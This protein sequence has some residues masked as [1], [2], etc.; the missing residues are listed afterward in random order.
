MDIKQALEYLDPDDDSHWTAEGLPRIEAVSSL[1]E[2]TVKRQEIT[3]A[4]PM[5]TRAFAAGLPVEDD[6]ENEQGDETTTDAGVPGAEVEESVEGD[7]EGGDGETGDGLAS[8]SSPIS[9]LDRPAGEILASRELLEQALI[10][11][12]DKVIEVSRRKSDIEKELASI[13]N[14]CV[15][16]SRHLD[17]MTK[18]DPGRSTRDIQAYLRRTHEARAQR[19]LRAQAFVQ[20]GTNMK[21]VIE[22]LRGGSRLDAAMERKRTRGTQRPEPRPLRPQTQSI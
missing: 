9:V 1:V 16:L 10:E 6:D 17:R 11:L 20:A 22:Q 18:H 19:V 8:P 5:F 4:A 3:D 2:R 15:I 12:G 14:Q 13:N 7:G 21:D